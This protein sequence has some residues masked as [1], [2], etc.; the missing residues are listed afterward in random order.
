MILRGSLRGISRL[1][2]VDQPVGRAIAAAE[3]ACKTAKERGRGRSEIY[4]D[5]DE[6]MMR[7]R[8]DVVGLGRLRDALR[9]GRL[10]MFGQ[11][12]AP[13]G[14]VSQAAG[15]ECLVRMVA[16]DGS[17]VPPGEF[18]SVAQRHQLLKKIDEWV[19]QNTLNILAPFAV[20]MLHSGLYASIN[21]SGQSLGDEDLLGRIGGWIRDSKVPPG[22]IMFEITESAAVS[23]LAKADKL[24]R[25]L[26]RMGCRFALD[27]FGTGVNSLSYLKT[28]QVQSVKIDG[29]FVRDIQTNARSAAMVEAIMKLTK[30]LQISCVAEFVESE[31][32]IRKLE[33]LGVE[34]VQGYY[35]QKPADLRAVFESVGNSMSQR[36][37]RLSMGE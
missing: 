37:R 16:S 28:L 1:M 2:N 24:M 26:R 4:L 36:R 3:L 18:M 17:I 7:R 5:V 32:I 21:I 27:D 35:I 23:N 30:S 29:S 14:D 12:I 9:N 31:A 22:R 34:F 6:S 10:T 19:I 20:S 8:S 25:N 15:I 13:I 11:I 33:K